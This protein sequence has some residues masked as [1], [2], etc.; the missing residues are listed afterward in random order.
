MQKPIAVHF[1]LMPRQIFFFF[2]MQHC[3]STLSYLIANFVGP[4]LI[5]FLTQQQNPSSRQS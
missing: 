2:L 1:T 4:W 5:D 3:F